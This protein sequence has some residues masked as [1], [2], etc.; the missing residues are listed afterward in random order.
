MQKPWREPEVAVISGMA[1]GI[2]GAGH[3]GALHAGGKTYGV[4]G[5][6]VDVCY[7]REHIGLYMDILKN[8]GLIAERAPGNRRCLPIFR[9]A[10]GSSAAFPM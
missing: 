1:R 4:L 3:R 10:T 2:D 9:S 6:G 8:G 7:P 5:C